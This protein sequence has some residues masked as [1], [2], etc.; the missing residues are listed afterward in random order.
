M[1]R[2]AVSGLWRQE[3]VDVQSDNGQLITFQSTADGLNMSSPM[4]DGYT[5]KFGG[6][7]LP[8]KNDPDG[9]TIAIKKIDSSTF[10]ET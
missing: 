10:E 2:H 9:G 7:A 6:P 5:A 8:V 4:G 3:K 1:G